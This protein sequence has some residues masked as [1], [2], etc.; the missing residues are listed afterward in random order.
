MF[1][2]LLAD[3]F[4]KSFGG[5]LPVF[6][7]PRTLWRG[8]PVQF[9]LGSVRNGF[10]LNRC[11]NTLEQ[12]FTVEWFCHPLQCA[13]SHRLHTHS[14]VALRCYKDGRNPP[15][16]CIQLRLQLQT[17]HT[18]HADIRD[19]ATS[20]VLSARVQEILRRRKRLRPQDR[21][22]LTGPAMQCAPDHHHQ[23]WQPFSP[24]LEIII[25]IGRDLPTPAM[26]R[27]LH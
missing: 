2:M 16:N 1:R 9:L 12:S 4:E 23:Q 15:V 7:N 6:F 22:L 26:A 27:Q 10:A 18:R 19:Q 17:G 25:V 20:V 3:R 5:A 14:R 21:P 13:C 24:S 11:S 8:A